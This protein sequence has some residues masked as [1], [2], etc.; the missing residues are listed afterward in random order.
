VEAA[1]IKLLKTL[2]DPTR[3]LQ[4][5]ILKELINAEISIFV[6]KQV[7]LLYCEVV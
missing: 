6:Y 1:K 5:E 7:L 2:V 4:C 3:N